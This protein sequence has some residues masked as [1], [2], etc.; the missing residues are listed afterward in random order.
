MAHS[1]QAATFL[2]TDIEGSTQL[3]ERYREHM[4]GALAQHD[5]VINT[6]LDQYGGRLVKHTGDGVF[7]I[8]EGGD[9]LR[10]VLEIQRGLAA[11]DWGPVGEI[12]VRMALHH[13]E[14]EQ[15]G[16]HY[17]G[18]RS[19]Q[20]LLTPQVLEWAPLPDAAWCEDSGMHLLKDLSEPQH[21]YALCHSDL[22]AEFPP[23]RPLSARPNNLPQQAT[24]FIGR[25]SELFDIK[26]LLRESGCR[27]VTLIGP[28]GMGR[29]RLSLQA[30]AENVEAF[31]HGVYFIPLAPI[32]SARYQEAGPGP[33][34]GVSAY[35][36]ITRQGGIIWVNR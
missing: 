2:F 18:W 31:P 35:Q 6:S 5:D 15:R 9:P 3:W 28:G 11:C 20:I 33:A 21:I 10:C 1:V 19:G 25:H 30:A 16:A 13:G 36:P 22:V 23:L 24:P 29:T 12:R 8:F 4:P 34:G 17:G 26:R 27:L 14:A 7:A 32:S